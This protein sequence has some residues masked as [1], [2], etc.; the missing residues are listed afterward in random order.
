MI[1]LFGPISVGAVVG[2]MLYYFM[3]KYKLFSPKTLAAT[4][5]AL[6]GGP[7]LTVLE[8]W[9]SGG[10][11][12]LGLWY[13]LG[14]GI[15][16]FVYALYAGVLSLLYAFGKIKSLS[17]FEV[18]VGC[19]AG[20]GFQLDHVERRVDFEKTLEQWHNGKLAEEAFKSA[21]STLEFS[22]IDYLRTKRGRQAE[23]EI[24]KSILSRFEEGRY[25]QYLRDQPID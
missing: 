2:W 1:E 3:R 18:A 12:K 15:G 5:G 25:L 13:F 10:D 8:R 11:A 14:V 4:L 22:K 7:V 23:F 6:A 24:E 9:A 17:K 20:L 16:F 19:G 21:L